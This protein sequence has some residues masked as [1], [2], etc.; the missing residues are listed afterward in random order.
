MFYFILPKRE[1]IQF[2]LATKLRNCDNSLRVESKM[3][4]DAQ[5]SNI[6]TTDDTDPDIFGMATARD[7][8]FGDVCIDYEE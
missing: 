1:R 3:A 4:D 2:A 5:I 8:K 6:R 7:F